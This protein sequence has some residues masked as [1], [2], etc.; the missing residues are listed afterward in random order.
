[1]IIQMLSISQQIPLVRQD[2]KKKLHPIYVLSAGKK[3]KASLKRNFRSKLQLNAIKII[4]TKNIS[5]HSNPSVNLNLQSFAI[6]TTVIS[7][8]LSTVSDYK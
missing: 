5:F 3:K 7:S 4:C 8:E 2:G 1:M 6:F